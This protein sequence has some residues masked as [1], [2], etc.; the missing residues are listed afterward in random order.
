[1]KK[2]FCCIKIREKMSADFSCLFTFSKKL[3]FS[4]FISNFR[5]IFNK[6][7]E[8]LGKKYLLTVLLRHPVKASAV[9]FCGFHKNITVKEGWVNYFWI[10]PNR[11]FQQYNFISKITHL[12]NSVWKDFEEIPP[13]FPNC[14]IFMKSTK[15]KCWWH[16]NLLWQ[17]LSYLKKS[18]FFL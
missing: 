7:A 10:F 1:M 12:N 17:L 3:V 13:T 4:F 9:D 2:I 16:Q 14:S 11:V 15:I 8:F 18:R 5:I 6:Y